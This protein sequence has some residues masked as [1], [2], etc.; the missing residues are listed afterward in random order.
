MKRQV[1]VAAGLVLGVAVFAGLGSLLLWHPTVLAAEGEFITK[2]IDAGVLQWG[3]LA[4]ALATGLSAVGAAYAVASVGAAAVGA[5]AVSARLLEV[6][7]WAGIL[8]GSLFG[9]IVGFFGSGVLLNA[10]LKGWVEAADLRRCQQQ[11]VTLNRVAAEVAADFD[12]HAA[13]DITGFG[14]AGH[15]LEVARGSRV[16]IH[17][18]YRDIPLMS[19]AQAMY[20]RGMTRGSN[21]SNRLL[22]QDEL[23]LPDSLTAAAQEL[24]FDPQT[25]GGLL[26]SLAAD[27]ADSL[28]Q[29]LHDAGVVDAVRIGTL[30]E[31]SDGPRLTVE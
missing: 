22:V 10:N 23:V 8:M 19:G 17:L 2:S 31:H 9:L 11:L 4:A 3:Y 27:A 29:Q 30:H 15:V 14:L 26:L 18:C 12:V 21:A 5:I 25:N 13:T 28:L 16:A 24:L 20:E 6:P 7:F 1:L